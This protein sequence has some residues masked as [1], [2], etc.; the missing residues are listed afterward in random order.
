MDIDI[1]KEDAQEGLK[2]TETNLDTEGILRV[3]FTAG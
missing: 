1:F 2:W 3:P